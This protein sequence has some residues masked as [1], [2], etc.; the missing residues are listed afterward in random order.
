[1]HSPVLYYLILQG[2]ALGPFHQGLTWFQFLDRKN[3]SYYLSRENRLWSAFAPM[4]IIVVSMIAYWFSPPILYLLYVLWT[5]QHIAK[6]NIGILLLYHNHDANEA[7]PARA[8]ETR[9]IE[10]FAAL[11]SFMFLQNFVQTGTA[12]ELAVTI[13]LIV[14]AVETTWT[15][16]KLIANLSLQIKGGKSLNVPA[17][18]F[19]ILSC[20]AFSP[21]LLTREINQGLFVALVMHWFQYIGLNAILV[22]RKYA[23]TAHTA[24]VVGKQPLICFLAVGILY[25]VI[26]MPVDLLTVGGI[27]EDA[28]GLRLLAGFVSG[29]TFSHYFLD[30]FIWRFRDSHNRA[31]ILA[32]VKTNAKLSSS[33]V[34]Q[35]KGRLPS[36]H[37]LEHTTSNVS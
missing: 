4:C 12:T 34:V 32:F 22:K 15:T 30:A 11:F 9:T 13:I 17:C 5:I 2:F 19:W 27:S 21:F 1:M 7:V 6:Q 18:G 16:S 10:S 20:L 3:S 37:F 8:L 28:W 24:D 29:L 31:S 14:L 33:Q 25:A 36:A 23:S 26:A 35:E